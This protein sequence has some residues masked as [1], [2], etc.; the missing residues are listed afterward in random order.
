MGNIWIVTPQTV[1]IELDFRGTPF[2]I[3]LKKE[4]TVG[5]EK[6]LY[7][8]GFRSVSRERGTPAAKAGEPVPEIEI[9]VDY[10]AAIFMKVKT[11]LV[12]WSLTDDKGQKLPHNL[13]GIM[14]LS[15]AVFAIIERAIDEHVVGMRTLEKKLPGASE[16]ATS[17]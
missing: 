4:L 13:D 8:S 3:E 1:R 6:R 17:A 11:Y 5:E 7:A 14:A 2:W 16:P 12:D 9:N 10:D 15:P